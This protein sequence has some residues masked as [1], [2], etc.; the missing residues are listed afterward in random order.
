MKVIR[1]IN[2]HLF[3]NDNLQRQQPRGGVAAP[4]A[5]RR[6]NR[7]FH[8]I[9]NGGEDVFVHRKACDGD[10]GVGSA[11]SFQEEWNESKQKT[12]A[13]QCELQSLEQTGELGDALPHGDVDAELPPLE[14]H[15]SA[16]HHA[17]VWADEEDSSDQ[18]GIGGID[19]ASSDGVD[20]DD[21][22]DDEEDED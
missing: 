14:E 16:I 11:V 8:N 7:I 22:D 4:A 5:L 15:I 19:D 6:R 21:D 2:V 13:S 18:S 3:Y 1:T 20:D 9:Q 12:Q 17:A 10:I